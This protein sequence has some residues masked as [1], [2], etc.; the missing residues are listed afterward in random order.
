MSCV[1]VGSTWVYSCIHLMLYFGFSASD[2]YWNEKRLFD[3][4]NDDLRCLMTIAFDL[5]M[6]ECR[7]RKRSDASH[8]VWT[9]TRSPRSKCVRRRSLSKFRPKSDRRRSGAATH[10]PSGA[11]LSPSCLRASPFPFY[12]S[13]FRNS[14]V[15]H[16]GEGV[17][18]STSLVSASIILI[19]VIRVMNS[20][21]IS[22]LMM[23]YFAT[24]FLLVRNLQ[25]PMDCFHIQKYI[26]VCIDIYKYI[27][28]EGGGWLTIN[29]GR[30]GP[31]QGRS[32]INQSTNGIVLVNPRRQSIT[33]NQLVN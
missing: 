29:L 5:W 21:W 18:I 19:D 8:S 11:P 23:I 33:H 24:C 10:P 9:P 4:V 27:F 15:L 3:R 26:Y 20:A 2:G 32:W 12:H 13:Y 30:V 14:T 22:A 25:C 28:G 1:P 16:N 17:S 31:D 7:R 6:K